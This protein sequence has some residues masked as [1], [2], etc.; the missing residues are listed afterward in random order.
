MRIKTLCSCGRLD[1]KCAENRTKKASKS[2]YRAS[3]HERYGSEWPKLSLRY[4][5]ANP[6]CQM[7][8]QEGRT[9]VAV[10]VHH[11]VKV[12]DN[13]SLLLEWDNLLSVCRK[14]H[15]KLDRVQ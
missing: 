12:A 1:C 9:E 10:D 5:K 3:K 7:C 14:C 11:I 15:Y 6:L 13:P 4:R 8:E 2:D